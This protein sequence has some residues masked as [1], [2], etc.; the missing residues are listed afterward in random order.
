ML[1]MLST[2]LVLFGIKN[3]IFLNNGA[4][5]LEFQREKMYR[6]FR[7]LNS[8]FLILGIAI[9]AMVHF[10]LSTYV[11]PKLDMKMIAFSVIVLVAGLYNILVS[12][13]WKKASKFNFYLY[14]SSQSYA[15]DLIYTVS[16]VM[17]M[18]VN[19]SI[20]EFLSEIIVVSVVVLVMNVLLGFFVRSMNRGYMNVNFRNL[21]SRLFLIAFVSIL[22]YYAGLLVV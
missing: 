18:V 1:K 8:L 16:V 11:Y 10:L 20:V 12:F 17:M 4:G 21:A 14:Q 22:F 2:Y 3:N 7:Y 9:T 15:F 19:V 6:S 13:I 5:A